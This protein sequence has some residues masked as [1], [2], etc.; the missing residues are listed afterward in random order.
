MA[1]SGHQLTQRL[2]AWSEGRQDALESRLHRELSL[3][4]SRGS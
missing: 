2:P 1:P 4:S 3:E